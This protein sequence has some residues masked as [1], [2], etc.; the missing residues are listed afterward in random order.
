MYKAKGV[1]YKHADEIH[2]PAAVVGF[3]QAD[4]IYSTP[5]ARHWPHASQRQHHV[6]S[7]QQPHEKEGLITPIPQN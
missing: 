2:L 5:K 6:P 4:A 3:T 1:E 7:S